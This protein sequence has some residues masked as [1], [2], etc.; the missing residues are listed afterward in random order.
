M[1]PFASVGRRPPLDVSER[2]I[3]MSNDLPVTHDGI[4]LP[5]WDEPVGRFQ[6]IALFRR[7]SL[8]RP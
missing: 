8:R 6:A 5:G 3:P 1:P 4:A 2:H 7:V